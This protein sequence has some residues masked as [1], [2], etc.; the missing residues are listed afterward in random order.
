M[1]AQI[2]V[3]QL[4]TPWRSEPGPANSLEWRPSSP[5]IQERLALE[6][7]AAALDALNDLRTASTQTRMSVLGAL[8]VIADAIDLDKCKALEE[9]YNRRVLLER[10]TWSLAAITLREGQMTEAHDHD[11]WGCVLIVQG[12]ERDR[13]YRVSDDGLVLISERDYLPGN[14]YLF[15]PVDIHQIAGAD[16]S[17]LTI[18]LHFLVHD[19]HT[20]QSHHEQPTTAA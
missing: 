1:E 4:S 6:A 5:V 14:G 10:P 20:I 2:I 17:R 7:F 15:D 9:H 13:R 12:I 19:A 18:A 16:R 8:Q 3:N 11:G